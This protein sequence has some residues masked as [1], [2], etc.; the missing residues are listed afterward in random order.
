ML[1]VLCD[2]QRS[3][4]GGRLASGT[5]LATLK[6]APSTLRGYRASHHHI[7]ATISAVNIGKL[8]RFI[9]KPCA[10]VELVATMEAALGQRRLGCRR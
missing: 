9:T 7:Q 3:R 2:R 8:F 10:P 1:N 4:R 5:A 6:S